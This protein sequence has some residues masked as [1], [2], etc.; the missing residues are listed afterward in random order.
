[1]DGRPAWTVPADVIA[2]LALAVGQR[3]PAG[4]I[5]RLDRAADE[6]G[7]FRAA[8]R[9]LERRAHG[10][11]ELERKLQRK[12]HAEVVVAAALVR[13]ERLGLLDDATFAEAY[14]AARAGRGRGPARLQRDLEALG[15]AT[16]AIDRALATI[17]HD[18]VP[19][20]WLRT[21][22]QATRRAAAI[23]GLPRVTRHRR[24]HAFFARRGFAGR[25]A[26]EAIERLLD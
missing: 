10:A 25:E 17:E 19:D 24:L 22:Q 5:E 16:A 9:L 18:D 13:L 6:E 15:V 20:P 8:L 1:V 3:M 26:R 4:A 7:A 2:E 23:K 21:L 11:R 12:G 14:V